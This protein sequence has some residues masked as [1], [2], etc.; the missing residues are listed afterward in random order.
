M[1]IRD[2]FKPLVAVGALDSHVISV[3]STFFCSGQTVIYGHRFSCWFKPGHGWV[4]LYT[5][6]K[7]SCNIYFYNVGKNLGIQRI[8]SYA[9]IFGFGSATEIDL[10]GEKYGLVPDPEWKRS[11]KNEPWYP[12]ETISVSIGQGPLLVTPLQVAVYTSIIANRGKKVIP[13]LFFSESNSDN[14]GGN[15]KAVF[16]REISKEIKESDFEKVITGLW[17]AVNEGGTAGAA[18]VEDFNV[19]GKTGSTQVVSADTEKKI[20][21]EIK[22]HSWFT[23]F[24]PR[25]NPEVIVTIIIEYGGMGGGI[26]AP[27]AKNLFKLYKDKYVR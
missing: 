26:A 20:G 10:P 4:N 13:H 17:M 27:L 14:D 15:N 23:G 8:A 3:Q 1:C 19:C 2:R 5:G 24:A 6:I 9:R 22:T 7:N 18:Y 11:T 25:D 16:L 12:G 21:R